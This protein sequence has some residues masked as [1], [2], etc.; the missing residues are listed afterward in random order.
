MKLRPR[1]RVV[2]E[3]DVASKGTITLRC[4]DVHAK[5]EDTA[6]YACAI[7]LVVLR[8]REGSASWAQCQECK[9]VFHE[10]CI[11]QHMRQHDDTFACPYCKKDYNIDDFE[12]K[13]LATDLVDSLLDG[14]DATFE[15]DDTTVAPSDRRLR[16]ARE[17]CV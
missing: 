16:S 13:W 5:N 12:D 2:I 8:V 6:P 15:P 1:A 11:V 3:S 14:E 7:C 4:C 17:K 10:A 9:N